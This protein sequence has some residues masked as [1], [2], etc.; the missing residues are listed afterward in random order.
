MI[1]AEDFEYPV[2]MLIENLKY[3]YKK[4]D[5]F[6]KDFEPFRSK[7]KQEII[8]RRLKQVINIQNL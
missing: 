2:K 8:Q 5:A 3:Q 6:K 7:D 1:L 4:D